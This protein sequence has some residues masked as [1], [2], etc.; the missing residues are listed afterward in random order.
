VTV[1]DPYT[2]Q[3]TLTH[4]YAATIATLAFTVTS[5]VSPSYVIAHCQGSPEMPGVTPGKTCDY[6]SN[7]PLGSGPYMVTEFTP[8]VRTVLTSYPGYWGGPNHLGPAAIKTYVINYVP[9]ISTRELDLFAGS[10]DAIDIQSANAFDVMDKTAWTTSQTVTPLKPGIRIWVKPT[11]QLVYMM[12]N[13]RN[14]PFDNIY[15]RKALAYAFPYDT[16]INQAQNGFATRLYGPLPPGIPGYDPSLNGYYDY[17]PQM[18]RQLFEQAGYNGTATI[19]VRTGDANLATAGLLLK[20]SVQSIYPGVTI[21]IQQVD[22]PTWSN[23]FRTFGTPL[24][25]GAWTWD[26]DDPADFL[27]FAVTPGG[28]VGRFTEFGYNS[29]L[30]NW[31]NQAAG[32]LDQGK[33]SQ[34][35]SL[36][37]HAVMATGSIIPLD[38]PTAI[39]VERDWV[40]PGN[41]TIGRAIDNPMW[42][43]GDGGFTGGYHPYYLW[44]AQ[45]TQQINVM[46]GPPIFVASTV[47]F[48]NKINN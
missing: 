27:P 24:D 48:P 2:V 16:F 46:I 11:L 23:L 47:L 41:S 13:P 15:F 21:Q 38:R 28:Q 20:D 36:L 12:I 6:M 7:N 9:E 5:I 31:A 35:Y 1:I 18:A 37:Q 3:I 10:T 22:T 43:D 26:I 14:P 30:V 19:S 45:F 29:T 4:P 32:E 8:K 17:N 42:G 44:K 40:Q 25:I 33:R 39:F 34:L